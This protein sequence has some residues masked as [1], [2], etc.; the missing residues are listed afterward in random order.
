ME[1]VIWLAI[2]VLGALFALVP[3]SREE[4]L[5]GAAA[6]TRRPGRPAREEVRTSGTCSYCRGAGARS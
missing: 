5:E 3:W 6:S 4:R 1:F 2:E